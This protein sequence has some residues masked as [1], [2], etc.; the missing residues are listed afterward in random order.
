[1]SLDVEG[2]CECEDLTHVCVDARA[3]STKSSMS[4]PKYCESRVIHGKRK[5]F[6]SLECKSC[7]CAAAETMCELVMAQSV[8]APERCERSPLW[9]HCSNRPGGFV[10]KPD[11]HLV[12]D[13][14]HGDI[15]RGGRWVMPC[16]ADVLGMGSVYTD[17]WPANVFWQPWDCSLLYYS[18][19]EVR[20]CLASRIL[21]FLGDST[22]RGLAVRVGA[23]FGAPGPDRRES[24]NQWSAHFGDSTHVFFQYYPPLFDTDPVPP[25]GEVS[26]PAEQAGM[27]TSQ[28]TAQGAADTTASTKRSS[29]PIDDYFA[30]LIRSVQQ[31]VGA[32]AWARSRVVLSVGALMLRPDWLDTLARVIASP[33]WAGAPAPLVIVKSRGQTVLHPS[34][35]DLHRKNVLLREHTERLARSNSTVVRFRWFE[36]ESITQPFWPHM[37]KMDRCV[38]HFHVEQLDDETAR[39]VSPITGPVNTKLAHIW[40]NSVCEQ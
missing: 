39:Q 29:P 6:F 4:V 37:V 11:P 13:S 27:T 24:H 35:F 12:L 7:R 21:L 40:L 9:P 36:T 32:E 15:S 16:G 2:L 14:C 23:M 1:M 18:R 25:L 17:D 22:L 3:A 31:Q 8:V 30:Y 33:L 20:T 38:C 10:L 19:Q 5:H 34:L 26:R 28:S